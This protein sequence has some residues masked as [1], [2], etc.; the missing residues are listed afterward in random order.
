MNKIL[1]III[2]L[3]GV[4]Q[5][6]SQGT[7]VSRLQQDIT[8]A[9][10]KM[11]GDIGV[12]IK[13]LADNQTL[14]HNTQ[15]MWYLS[16][17]I[18]IP[19][20]IAVLMK[21]EEGTIAL[22]DKLTLKQSDYVDGGGDIL[23]DE[24]GTTYTVSTLIEKSI[25]HSDSS[26]TDMLIRLIGEDEFN[27]LIRERIIPQGIS[28]ITTIM[29]VRHEAYSEVHPS[30][31]N[32][33]NMDIIKINSASTLADRFN[34]LTQAL[35]VDK[36]EL[37]A[38]SI[39]EAFDRFYTREINKASLESMGMMLEK[40]AKGELLNKEHTDFLLNA[41]SRITTGDKRIKAGLPKNTRFAHK[42]GTQIRR[43][44]DMGIIYPGGQ[45]QPIIITVCTQNYN[46]IGDAE[47]AF[48]E[49]G[50]S[51]ARIFLK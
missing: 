39:D 26:A 9:D 18:K 8:Q 41:M 35:D 12:F 13:N 45:T 43:A 36:N 15:Q 40:L 37:K 44:C 19:L 23:W 51:V 17:T 6:R 20:A 21:V 22:S 28:R 48:E 42:T 33:T 29:Q 49:I 27:R 24:P 46:Q 1:V 32:L 25:R 2:L 50:R 4:F 47:K 30:A 5:Q 3:T 16:S 10:K 31:A 34:S 11:E 7:W 14:S 38:S